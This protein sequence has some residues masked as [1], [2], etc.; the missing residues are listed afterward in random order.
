MIIMAD[1]LG[2]SD[3]GV[4][5]GE[6][7]T[8]VLDGLAAGGLLFE[9]FY[10]QGRCYPT[11]TSLLT[12]L[13]PHRAGVGG[14]V[15]PFGEPV[16]PGP[17]QGFLNDRAVTVAEALAPAGYR[18][19]LSG[20]WHVGEDP[21][22]WPLRRGFDRYFGLISGASSY[23]EV[24]TDQPRVRQMAYGDERWTPPADGFY[25]SD[26][27]SDTAAAFV[28]QHADEHGRAPFFLYVAYTAPHWPLHA[29]EETVR[30]YAGRYD[31][32]WDAV[33]AARLERQQAMGLV[34]PD[35]AVVGRPASVPA[36]NDVPTGERT[37][38]TRRMEVY[39][40]MVDRMDAGIGRVLDALDATGVREN[41]VVLFLSDN[42][43]SA[44]SIAG[45]GLNDPTVPVGQ[46]GSYVAY[47]E[48]WAW[49]SS[50]PFRGYKK[51]AFEGGIA[52]P[53]V[54]SWPA[55]LAAPG[56]RTASAGSVID[57]LPTILNLAGADYPKA[58][59]GRAIATTDGLSLTPLFADPDR[60]RSGPLFFEHLGARGL[61]DGRWKL[62]YDDDQWHLF[63]LV[64]D[65]FETSDVAERHGATALRLADAWFT[66]AA[67]VGV[68]LAPPA[69]EP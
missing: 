44:E 24:I 62:V 1:D 46:P 50:T 49:V 26:A 14:A 45:R 12:G 47:R 9:R 7:E 66:W 60:S 69:V 68:R 19:Y 67:A 21:E 40:A 55:G 22:H 8:P 57:L 29:P 52:T 58:L 61:R 16:E 56:R 42:G 13:Y 23:W 63:D 34:A 25:M 53:M 33:R 59:G 65:P 35:A 51:E 64:A 48:P 5:G 10:N 38:W 43:A 30:A 17:Y 31:V 11:R 6:I 28:R 4:T 37:D 15:K 2:Y 32:G 39:A 20:K 18:S 41:T 27:I 36:W 3:L 54:V